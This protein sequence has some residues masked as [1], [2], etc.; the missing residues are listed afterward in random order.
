[1]AVTRINYP[2]TTSG[3]NLTADAMSKLISAQFEINRLVSWMNSI[4]S[5]GV[6][7][8]NLETDANFQIPSG[9]GSAF[10]THLNDI[11]AGLAAISATEI[12][13]LDPGT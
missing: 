2:T 5:G 6:M 7:P 1:M 11:K 4:T 8:A 13:D 10:Y 12:A 9:L 3:G